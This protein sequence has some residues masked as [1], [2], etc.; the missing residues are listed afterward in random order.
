MN[1]DAC[2]RMTLAELELAA[3]PL[4]SAVCL[5]AACDSAGESCN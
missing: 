2:R 1:V 4:Q 5:L 3:S